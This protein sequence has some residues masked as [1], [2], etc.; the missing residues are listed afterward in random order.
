MRVHLFAAILLFACRQPPT[1]AGEAAAAAQA[2]TSTAAT[3]SW[4]AVR[5]VS[6]VDAP[7]ELHAAAMTIEA[8]V[9]LDG[10]EHVW[11]MVSPQQATCWVALDVD[12]PTMAALAVREAIAAASSQL[13]ASLAPP[14]IEA[15]PRDEQ[16]Y[17]LHIE[18]DG[19]TV[20]ELSAIAAQVRARVLTIAGVRDARRCG[21]ERRTV[22]EIDRARTAAFGIAPQR[23]AELLETS[24]AGR[25][26]LDAAQLE[27]A[28]L[29]ERAG[30]GAEQATAIATVREEFETA[31]EAPGG[32]IALRL[33]LTGDPTEALEPAI[34]PLR[35]ELP[36]GVVVRLMPAPA[37]PREAL[38]VVAADEA[39]RER[40]TPLLAK[41]AARELGAAVDTVHASSIATLVVTPDRERA[42]RL[43]VAL[44][45]IA[46]AVQLAARRGRVLGRQGDTEGTEVAV[47]IGDGGPDVLAGV[48]V[49]GSDGQQLPLGELATVTTATVS[50]QLRCDRRGCALLASQAPLAGLDLEAARRELALGPEVSLLRLPLPLTD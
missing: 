17:W 24:N 42:A 5:V 39:V 49:P 20:A 40:V 7:D 4:I 43:G 36:V 35:S 48:S 23:V 37:L 13:P 6:P 41:W 14:M 10:V 29:F 45:A 9:A 15:H 46:A 33:R 11:T 19:R 25:L 27:P 31:C 8:A 12:D 38:A 16:L 18:G 28:R 22:I 2:P 21:P 34:A 3:P 30:L 50:P 1:D 44:D 26:R 47:R 32:G